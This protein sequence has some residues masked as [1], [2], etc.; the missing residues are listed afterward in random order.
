MNCDP[1]TVAACVFQ[2]HSAAHERHECPLV[3]ML[4]RRLHNLGIQDSP[5]YVD[6]ELDKYRPVARVLGCPLLAKLSLFDLSPQSS[7][8]W[9][10]WRAHD[11]AVTGLP[12]DARSSRLATP[13][14]PLPR[15]A[16]LSR[17]R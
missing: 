17:D 7:P 11:P 4:V 15:A 2:E 9:P 1:Q 8:R 10:M 5:A 14:E 12:P 13:R 3:Q 6:R 16:A